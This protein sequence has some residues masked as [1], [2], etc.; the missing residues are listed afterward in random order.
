MFKRK[1]KH[2][3]YYDTAEEAAKAYDVA[4]KDLFGE[5]AKLNF[6]VKDSL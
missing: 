1:A 6:P 4:A 3:G 2:I 5:F